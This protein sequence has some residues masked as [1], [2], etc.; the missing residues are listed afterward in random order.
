MTANH[1][2]PLPPEEATTV[3][4]ALGRPSHHETALEL[5]GPLDRA[6]I[7]AA[8]DHVAVRAPAARAWRHR[9]DRHGPRHHTLRLTAVDAGTPADAY[10]YGLL[11]DLL[12]HPEDAARPT[13]RIRP[14]P[15]QRELLA[16]ADANPGRHVEQLAWSWHGPLDEDR[17]RA[18]WQCVTDRE[19][20][21]RTVFDDGPEPLLAVHDHV[22]ADVLC[23]PA[24]AAH[25]ADLVEDDRRRGIDPR[26]P[27]ALRVTVLAA[28]RPAPY[29]TTPARVL[30]TYHHALLDDFSVRLLLR[31]FYR[32]YLADG[33]LPGGERRPDLRDY[34]GWLSGQDTGPAQDYW[35]R[36]VRPPTTATPALPP[37]APPPHLPLPSAATGPAGHLPAAAKRVRLRLTAEQTE[38]L[39]AWAARWG[40]TESVALHAVWAVLLY[41]AQGAEAAARVRFH[42]AAPGRGILLDGVESLPAAL[43]TPLPLC[44][45]VDPRATVATLLTEVRD[46]VLDMTAYEWVSPGQA[47]SWSAGET[48]EPDGTARP[49]GADLPSAADDGSLL[50]FENRPRH[51]DGLTAGLAAEGIRVEPAETLGALT[52]FPLTLAAHHHDD[53]GLVLTASHDPSRLADVTEILSGSALLLSELPYTAGDSM[54]VADLLRLLPNTGTPTAQPPGSPA[55]D[56]PGPA[57]DAP[58]EAPL[59]PLR[60]AVVPG[61]GTICLVPSRGIPRSWYERLARAYR[62]PEAMVLLHPGPGGT[63]TGHTALRGL[64]DP[65]RLVVVGG[66]SGGGSAAYETARLIAEAGGRPPLLV[67]TSAATGPLGLA[68]LLET[69]ATRADRT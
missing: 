49:D 48:G 20:A 25:W 52:A 37:T 40:G 60:A 30:L 62:G 47:R 34:T 28:D 43:R 35:A 11:A 14:T 51:P 42:V 6:R 8:L 50:V 29:G 3:V 32:A 67:L 7:E 15:L 10:P 58:H 39:R 27:G 31:E 66:F 55:A 63:H 56:G 53:G 44:V 26:R 2:W 5:R 13:W 22:T 69:T 4:V 9:I 16:D 17:F 61:A 36:T 33:R 41:R 68:R 23:L 54:T 21:L 19:S 38:R 12:T 65:A 57:T 24:G 18:S 45:E 64:T 1:T 46:H 59:E